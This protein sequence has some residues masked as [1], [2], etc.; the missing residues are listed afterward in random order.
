MNRYVDEKS[1]KPVV[2]ERIFEFDE[3][4]Q[5]YEYMLKQQFFGKVVIK[6]SKETT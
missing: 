5:A 1:I 2:D 4:R 3:V 6:V